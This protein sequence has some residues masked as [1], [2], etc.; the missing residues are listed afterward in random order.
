MN[1]DGL[2]NTRLWLHRNWQNFLK[3]KANLQSVACP[4]TSQTSP[5]LAS[6]PLC[7]STSSILIE[8]FIE[9]ISRWDSDHPWPEVC[10]CFGIV[11]KYVLTVLFLLS[12]RLWYV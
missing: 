11:K 9:L 6:D 2:R 8:S 5:S 10:K 7:Q 4:S 12:Y 1:T 3:K